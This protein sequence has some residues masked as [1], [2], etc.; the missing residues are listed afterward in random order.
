MGQVLDYNDYLRKL[1]K[2]LNDFESELNQV[3]EE[4]GVEFEDVLETLDVFEAEYYELLQRR[5]EQL[6]C[7]A[8]IEQLF[9]AY[10]RAE[11][12]GA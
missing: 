9:G 4:N 3:A 11:G 2:E 7:W 10:R 12:V 8:D 5:I 1:N 6:E